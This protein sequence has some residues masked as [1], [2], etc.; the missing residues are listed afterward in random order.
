MMRLFFHLQQKIFIRINFKHG[1]E[2]HLRNSLNNVE[3]YKIIFKCLKD[4][5]NKKIKNNKFSN[6]LYLRELLLILK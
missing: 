6:L 1:Q 5:I 3:L 2:H 4:M